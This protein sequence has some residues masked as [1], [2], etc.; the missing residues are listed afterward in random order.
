[1]KTLRAMLRH[2]KPAKA[3]HIAGLHYIA[4]EVLKATYPA[5]RLMFGFKHCTNPGKVED[6]KLRRYLGRF[7]EFP[8]LNGAGVPWPAAKK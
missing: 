6:A 8:P 7:G 3:G 2:R 1:L 5:D 4:N